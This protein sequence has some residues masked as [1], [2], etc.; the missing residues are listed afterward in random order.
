MI[1]SA[2]EYKKAYETMYA[3][4]EANGWGDPFSYARS[5]EIL[6]AATLNH[7]ISDT[8][9]GADAIDEDGEAEY[10][11]TIGKY[12][13]GTYNGISVWPTWEKQERYLIEDKIGKYNNHYFARFEGGKIVEIWKLKGKDVLTILLPKLRDKF[14]TV[15]EKKDPRLG[16]SITK[17]E[18]EDYGIKVYESA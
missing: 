1:I 6:I 9:S 8:L 11:S 4:C 16:A 18:I 17:T 5:K 10:K 14:D 2:Q 13:N 3:I 15:L 7:Q 12:I